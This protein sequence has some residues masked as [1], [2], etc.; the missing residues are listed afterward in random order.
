MDLQLTPEQI[1]EAI[2]PELE[3][4]FEECDSTW[5]AYKMLKVHYSIQKRKYDESL[6]TMLKGVTEPS[7]QILSTFLGQVINYLESKIQS[8]ES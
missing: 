8:F 3:E 1:E 2:K 7:I 4:F 5:M 6:N